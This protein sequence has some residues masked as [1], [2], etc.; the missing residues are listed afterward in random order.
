[1]IVTGKGALR[2]VPIW[3]GF[4]MVVST[5]TQSHI[6]V[7]DHSP[8]VINVLRELLSD[9]GYRVSTGLHL[10][11]DARS[12][13]ES[14]PDLIVIDYVWETPD[15]NWSLLQSIRR[16]P[17]AR[18]IPIVLCTGSVRQ[19]TGMADHLRS[20]QIDVVLKP[21]DIDR[22]LAVVSAALSRKKSR[23]A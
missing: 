23:P 11:H 14:A 10:S 5:P 6:L 12:V 22:F 3:K 9:E 1:M 15:E 8:D 18:D 13:V 7:I 2:S 16:M 21:F 20:L 4:L 19:A 17:P